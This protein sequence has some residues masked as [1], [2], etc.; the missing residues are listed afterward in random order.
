MS[1]VSVPATAELTADNPGAAWEL[2][3]VRSLRI[4]AAAVDRRVRRLRAGAGSARLAALVRCLDLTALASDDTELSIRRLCA[5]ARRPLPRAAAR[6]RQ[7]PAGLNRVAAVCVHPTFVPAAV[8]A[9]GGSGIPVAA[10]CAGFPHGLTPMRA[11]VAEIEDAVAAGAAEID[12][13]IPRALVL[14]GRW[15]TLFDEV[16]AY[17]RACGHARLKVIL[18]TGDLRSLTQVARAAAVAAMAGAHF[19][20]T[21]TGRE[22]VNATLPVGVVL[23]RVVRRYRRRTEHRV[24]IK[25]AGG[26]RRT[27]D[28]LAWQCLVR[29]ELGDDWTGPGLFR[30]GASG[31]LADIRARLRS[32]RR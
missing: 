11:R 7:V 16:V 23:A 15:R 2:A 22:A 12:A 18:G 10:A 19:V 20:K 5:T 25:P 21:S 6:G 1:R 26:I 28:A 8:T 30:I 13:V 24:G 4:D 29:E 9:L 3:W 14:D 32:A 27:G 17:R 31:L